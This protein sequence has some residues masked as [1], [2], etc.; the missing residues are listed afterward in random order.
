MKKAIYFF[1]LLIVFTLTGCV[2]QR[3]DVCVVSLQN[4]GGTY[5]L[6]ALRIDRQTGKTWYWRGDIANPPN[7]PQWHPIDT[8]Q[9]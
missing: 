2:S 4:P 5:S 3:Y 6:M 9:Q 8:P 7:N 1:L